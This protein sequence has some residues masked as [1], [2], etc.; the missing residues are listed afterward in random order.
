M[1]VKQKLV[2]GFGVIIAL[3]FILG[4]MGWFSLNSSSGGFKD[5]REMARDGVLMG[6]VQANMLMVRMNV[7]DYLN[8]P[9]E[10]EINEFNQYYT[11]TIGFVNEALKEI[12]KP[13]RA[14]LV[15]TIDTQLKEY[16]K[17]FYT[18]IDYMNKRNDIVNNNL[19]NNGK[20]IEQLLTAVMQSAQRDNDIEA[21]LATAKGIRTLLLAR[22]YTAKYIKSN[23]KKDANRVKKEFEELE[24]QLSDIRKEVQN[25][26]RR[27]QLKN[28][29]ILIE[30]YKQGVSKIVTIISQRNDIINNK[31]N[32]I[33]PNI[34]KLSE[35]VKLSIK[36]D[37]DTI[38][39][40]VQSSNDTFMTLI[41]I[42][43][44]LVISVA[45]VFAVII[46]RL[47]IT[48][49]ES[50]NK[51]LHSFFDFLNKKTTTTNKIELQSNDEFGVM[52]SMINENISIVQNTLKQDEELIN[53]VKVIVNQ[54]ESGD[55]SS[56]INGSTSNDSLNELKSIFNQMLQ[57]LKSKVAIDLN[58]VSNSLKKYADQD[59]TSKINDNGEFAKQINNLLEIINTMLVENMQNGLT[60]DAS[61][62]TLLENV[63]TLNQNS[64]AAAASL[65]ETAAA[66]EEVT[67]NISSTT[68]NVVEMANYA[69]EVTKSVED[70]QQLADQTTKAMDDID[71][72]VTAI[73]EAITVI[74]QIAFQTNILSLNAAVE[75]A[76]AGE[77]GKGFAVVAQEVR[78]L[79]ARSAEAANEIKALVENATTKANSGKKIADNMIQGYQGLNE[80]IS[81]TIE[82]IKDVETASQEQK[83]GI[84]QINDAI[85]SLDKQTQQNASIA[86]QTQAVATQT[87]EIA[88]LIVSK[89]NES[90]FIGKENVQATKLDSTNLKSK[91]QET[92]QN[93]P[94]KKEDSEKT[95]PKT[96]QEIEPITSD[97]EDNDEWASF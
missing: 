67:S 6:R 55:L 18:V 95:T 32:K 56:T 63:A 85:N 79:A 64:N 94:I 57:T 35:D 26:K 34:A 19:D 91:P 58:K 27:A 11:K 9:I 77:A 89:T 52:A 61:S 7:K 15:K 49:L 50:V 31:L 90:Q 12:Q 46:P 83:T 70:G 97:S 53:E 88:K 72:E 62:D 43:S 13:T 10:K 76:T 39:P 45:L 4:A 60:L 25:P 74:D 66:L 23:A 54:V 20:K 8:T 2:T 16:K 17:H 82:L 65:E 96:K 24:H 33:G 40:E 42:V 78:N 22:L 47:I 71:A 87:D 69:N 48:S 81:K 14:P 92:L 80:S 51:G 68:S 21:S 29:I 36:K 41:T 30:T 84:V 44:L 59:F 37:Q 93:K 1:N 75:A 86:S 73:N 38:G 5:Y 3:I 28:A